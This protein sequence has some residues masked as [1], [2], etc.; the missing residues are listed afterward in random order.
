MEI[1]T[2]IAVVLLL[3]F[4]VTLLYAAMPSPNTGFFKSDIFPE[5]DAIHNIRGDVMREVDE[6]L[7]NP[8][9]LDNWPEKDLYDDGDWKIFPLYA[10]N[11]WV[12]DNCQKMPTLTNFVKSIPN[13]RIALLSKLSPGMKLK[14]HRGW[15]DHSNNVL[16]CHYGLIVPDGCYIA[17]DTSHETDPSKINK[18]YH[19][20]DSWLVFDDSETHFAENTS[21]KERLVLIVD[22]QRPDHI[23][24]G[25]STLGDTKEL[26]N[27]VDY[28]KKRNIKN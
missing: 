4:L 2:I 6:V 22:I 11:T 17:V 27:I 8:Q 23:P 3:V 12:D 10:F 16:R 15:K 1:S 18:Q 5:L 28:Y 21:D 24:K 14:P 7:M 20:N 9:N 26:T 19:K 13:L 25:T